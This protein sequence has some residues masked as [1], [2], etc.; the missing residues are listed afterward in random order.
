MSKLGMTT[1][2]MEY[3]IRFMR[4]WDAHLREYIG[5]EIYQQLANAFTKKKAL[6]VILECSSREEV[7][8]RYAILR[9]QNDS[10]V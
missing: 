3:E 4:E 6:Q 5:D 9:G 1:E 8:K 2:Q 10:T 7:E